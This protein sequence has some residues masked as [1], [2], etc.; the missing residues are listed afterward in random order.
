MS[1]AIGIKLRATWSDWAHRNWAWLV[2]GL[3][4]VF[5][6]AVRL[7]LCDM[8]LERDE[9]EYAYAGQLMLQGVPPYKEAYNMKLPGTYAAYALIMAVIG[10]TPAGIHIGV[11]LVNI[12]TVVLVFLLG[13]KMLDEVAGVVAAVCFALMSLSPSVLGLAGHAT[14][15]VT[16]FALAGTLL[17]L[18]GMEGQRTSNIQ[19]PTSNVE[20]EKGRNVAKGT[21]FLSG[22]MFGLAFLMKQHGVF[23]AI[24]A[25]ACLLWTRVHDFRQQ[26]AEI[27]F[28]W[29]KKRETSGKREGVMQRSTFRAQTGGLPGTMPGTV[30]GSPSPNE[31]GAFRS[32]PVGADERV[33]GASGASAGAAQTTQT[34]VRLAKKFQPSARAIPETPKPEMLP[35]FPWKRTLIELA[36]LSWGMVLPY[37]MTCL[38]LLLCG[39]FNQF[40]FWTVTYASVY[41]W[42]VPISNGEEL[43]R[44]SVKT[45]VG[46]DLGFWALAASGGFMMWWESRLDMNRRAM[47]SFFFLCA[48]GSVGVGF[49]FRAHYF[50]TFLPAL[51]LL[52]GI[53]VSRS[54]ALIRRDTSAELLL[55]VPI[56]FLGV[57]A[58]GATIIGNSAVWFSNTPK[59]AAEEIYHTTL[60]SDARQAADYI[61]LHTAKSD[62]IAVIGSEPEIYFYARR[63][64]STGFIYAYPFLERHAY[65]G[66]MQEQAI[67]EIERNRP[68]FVAFVSN[69]TSFEPVEGVEQRIF[70]W[71]P[72]YWSKNL[73]VVSSLET[74]Q[75]EQ[76]SGDTSSPSRNFVLILKRKKEQESKL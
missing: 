51:S 32:G 46:P 56:L 57:A 72:K 63:R 5:V 47:L 33:F 36:S 76:L 27:L 62:K 24:F 73:D 3:T 69:E 35:P 60:Y 53:A 22:L 37:A 31:A 67:A 9:G 26:R 44:Q 18:K 41:A 30:H 66:K 1:Q 8:P 19:L 58:F 2:V 21:L 75:G 29:R 12:A 34:D 6:M 43:L 48:I 45:V 15:F 54:F 10:Q 38:L 11:M 23:F 14:H 59:E 20:P 64:G 16:L 68:E 55:A 61:R 40:I 4:I 52:A 50:I 7:R 13:R 70:D 74:R 42:A 71:W 49:Y 17:L 39:V 28:P 25:V 65:A